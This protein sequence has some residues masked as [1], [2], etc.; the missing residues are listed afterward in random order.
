MRVSGETC[1][2]IS[3]CHWLLS[4][5]HH[6]SHNP[7]PL[8]IPITVVTPWYWNLTRTHSIKTFL[9]IQHQQHQHSRDEVSWI[10]Q[11]NEARDKIQFTAIN[12]WDSAAKSSFDTILISF[13]WQH[14]FPALNS[15]SH[16]LFIFFMIY[17]NLLEVIIAKHTLFT[18]H[19]Y[20]PDKWWLKTFIISLQFLLSER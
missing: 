17:L 7:T 9:N 20:F 6:P 18:Y 10:M 12:Y 3:W 13:C 4:T 16:D 15:K 14:F 19:K 1:H 2:V 8:S 5:M 11:V